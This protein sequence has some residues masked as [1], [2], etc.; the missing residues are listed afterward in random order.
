MFKI[1]DTNNIVTNKLAQLKADGIETVIRYIS[2][3]NSGGKRVEIDEA[4][5]I[6]ASDLNLGLVF[7]VWG[8]VDNFA[9]NDINYTNGLAHGK[10]SKDWAAKVGAPDKTI[11]WFAI[12][13]DVVVNQYE[14]FVKPY[15][16]AARIA[17]DGKYRLGVYACG[18]S[19]ERAL[20]D[21]LVDATW[22]T[23]SMGWNGSRA[24]RASNKWTLLQ[25]PE[26]TLHGLSI[27][28]NTANGD[29]YGQ[30]VPFN[31]KVKV[32]NHFALPSAT[33][34]QVN[35]WLQMVLNKTGE[36]LAVDGDLG[37]ASQKAIAKVI[38]GK[39]IL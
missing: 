36:T 34:I 21:G 27:D 10:F 15:L 7:E 19:C 35:K 6:A 24:F 1:I 9:H 3:S 22:L 31:G 2:T 28:S 16:K 39:D 29:D 32:E 38:Y 18:D 33:P 11:I 14:V 37:P 23:Q 12:D 20:A 13:T 25:G 8:G 17:L 5:A 26:T 4:K 30:F